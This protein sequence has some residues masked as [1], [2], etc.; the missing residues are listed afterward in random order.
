MT[1]RLVAI[2]L[3]VFT[4]HC[5]ADHH[6]TTAEL[7]AALAN[8]ERSEADRGRDANRKPAEVLEFLGVKPGM[9][10]VDL[11]AAGGYYTEVLSLAVGEDGK[12]W[13]QNPP[14]FL[15]FRDGA[16]DK[17]MTARLADGRLANVSRADEDIDSL[18]IPSGS[19]DVVI[20]ALNFHD[21]YNGRGKDAAVAVSK[22]VYALLKPGGSFGVI[23]HIGT[24]GNDNAA[25]HRMK[26]ADAL[27]ALTEAGF[28]ITASS[29]LLHNRQDP[30]DVGVFDPSIRGNTDRFLIHAIKVR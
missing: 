20:T 4:G 29:T 16:N 25:L 5:L 17:A 13:A 19:V 3:L 21:I 22:A 11:M 10:V 7:K 2:F 14:A 15:R 30:H 12:V 23:D 9:T 6:E 1:R 28:R 18:S 8:P 27:E 24:D 26:Y